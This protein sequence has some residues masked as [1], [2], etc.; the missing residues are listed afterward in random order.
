VADAGSFTVNRINIFEDNARTQDTVDPVT[1]HDPFQLS[2]VISMKPSADMDG[3]E[4]L[5]VRISNFSIDGVTLVWLDGAN[6]S[7]IVE[8]TDGN[9]NVLYY[10]IP[11]SQLTNVEVL[12][13][14][15]SNDD[16]TFN[17]EGIVKDSA[18]LST[19]SA[20]DV[21]SLGNKTVIVDV[22]G[23]ADIPIVE[24]NDK[25]GIWQEFDDG[26]VRGVQT[27]VDENG[28][29]DI[30]FS[31]L[32]GEFK[33]N[34]ND[35]SETVT[36]LLSNIPDGVEIFDNDGNSVDLTFVGYD[37]NNQ[38]IYEANITQANINSGIV[39]KPEASSTENIHITATTIVTENDGHTRTST[40]EIRVIV[41][42]VID[43]RNNYTVVSEGDE[44]TRFN[45]D[46]KPTTS[47]SP[48]ADEFFSEVTI[49]GFPP[50]CTVFVDGVAQT[51]VAG[52]LTLTPQANESEQDFSARVTQSGYVQVE[53]E[54]DSS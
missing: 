22:K 11:E 52:T 8:V 9:G 50:S 54:Q 41:G 35:H 13:P 18:S 15:H 42:P 28:Q 7:Q 37:G 24:L 27:F 3:S 33:D 10:E 46:W 25:S 29:V 1:D 53:L 43:A 6:P 32:S 34:P 17:V 38:P 21:L 44:D 12:P 14:L 45:I 47:Q 51:L 36:V 5:F 19:G 49:S 16:F 20:Q 4:E 40:G 23:V 2:E 30:S 26:N 48:D 31:I 39:I